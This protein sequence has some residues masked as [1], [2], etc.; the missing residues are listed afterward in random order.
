LALSALTSAPKT[1]VPLDTAVKVAGSLV[2]VAGAFAALYVGGL[3]AR[4]SALPPLVVAVLSMA[5]FGLVL[6]VLYLAFDTILQQLPAR[7][8]RRLQP[9]LFVGPGLIMVCYFV[10]LPMVRTVYISFL[11]RDGSAFTGLANYLTIFTQPFML[12]T[13]RN[14]LLWLVFGAGLTV[15]F[16]LVI[17]ALVDQRRYERVAK[18]IIFMPMAI[19][20]VGA[21][22]I[23]KFIYAYKDESQPQIGLLN[24]LVVALGGEPQAWIQLVQPWNNFF[25][26]GIVIWLQTGYAMVLF[27]AAIKSVPGEYL[28]AARID[29][30]GEVR[31]FFDIVVPCIKTT[32]IAVTATVIIFTLKIFDVVLVMTGGQYGTDV[33]ATQFFTQYFVHRNAGLGSAIAVVLL[34]AVLP[35]IIYNIRNSTRSEPL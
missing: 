25:L 23:W 1:A 12:V 3:L 15:V 34:V 19:S 2:L 35:V 24:A 14:N 11:N 32:I 30:A 17:A 7:W 28:E 5:G 16:G 18:A 27:S 4:D 26:I 8:S 33:I 10:A 9:L 29:G 21:G 22:V 31:I 6:A 13:F 20:L